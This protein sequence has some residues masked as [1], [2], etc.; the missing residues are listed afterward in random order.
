MVASAAFST[1]MREAATFPILRMLK[2]ELASLPDPFVVPVCS[3][4]C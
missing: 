1:P 2:N 3:K 4:L